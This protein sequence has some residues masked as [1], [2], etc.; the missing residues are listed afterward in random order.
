MATLPK[1]MRSKDI[2]D[3]RHIHTAVMMVNSIADYIPTGHKKGRLFIYD[4]LKRMELSPDGTIKIRP[5]ETSVREVTKNAETQG[6][7]K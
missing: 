2:H 3:L 6:T 4:L 5:K 1:N 7:R